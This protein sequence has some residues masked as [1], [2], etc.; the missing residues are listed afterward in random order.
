MSFPCILAKSATIVALVILTS[1][2]FVGWIRIAFYIGDRVGDWLGMLLFVSAFV[3]IPA[4]IAWFF[5]NFVKPFVF[6][7]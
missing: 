6:G 3:G 5:I 4:I 1:L 7:T 2:L